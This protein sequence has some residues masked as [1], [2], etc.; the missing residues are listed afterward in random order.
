MK[1]TETT[2]KCSELNN[3]P[4]KTWNAENPDKAIEAGNIIVSVN[5]SKL[6]TSAKEVSELL[7]ALPAGKEFTIQFTK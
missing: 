2:V 3:G 5:G 7:K 1:S 6:G 4:I